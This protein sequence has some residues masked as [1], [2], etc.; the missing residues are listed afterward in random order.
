MRGPA[1]RVPRA[2]PVADLRRAAPRASGTIALRSRERALA[3]P[4]AVRHA[5]AGTRARP[6]RTARRRCAAGGPPWP[7][8]RDRRP[9][10]DLSR[11][12]ARLAG[13]LAGGTLGPGRRAAGPPRTVA[14][15]ALAAPARTPAWRVRAASLR[16]LRRDAARRCGGG[17]APTRGAPGRGV[18]HGE[19]VAGADPAA[20]QARRR[21]RPV[22]LRLRS[23]PGTLERPGRS[24]DAGPGARA[25]TRRGVAL[26]ERAGG[27]GQLGAR[28]ARPGGAAAGTRGSRGRP[29]AG[30]VSRARASPRRAAGR[31]G[32]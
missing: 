21:S 25:A 10:R 28:P 24:Q 12:A 5:A 18:R 6:A 8:R 22:H 31:L 14:A 23:L 3:D 29:G 16:P 11:L 30:A 7:G 9:L 2:F 32:R 13:A 26:R 15:L 19:P 27:A 1:H 20:R 17:R 4:A